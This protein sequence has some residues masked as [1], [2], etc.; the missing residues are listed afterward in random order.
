MQVV[1]TC[2]ACGSGKTRRGGSAI[3][4]VYLILIAAALAAVLVL[5]LH[6]GIVAGIMIAVIV[7]AHLL[8]DQRIC[9][10]CGHQWKG[11]AGRPG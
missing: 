8:I 11:S 5:R 2:P 9:L 6:S 7:I 1:A 4:A 10:D 3:W